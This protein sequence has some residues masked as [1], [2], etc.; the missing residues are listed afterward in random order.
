MEVYLAGELIAPSA[1]TFQLLDPDGT[2][3]IDAAA[4][5][6]TNDVATF[7]ISALDLPVTVAL[8]SG[9]V[10]VW[11][12]TMGAQSLVV[13]REAA[14]SK[15][16]LHCPVADV[17]FVAGE[18][19]DIV[20]SLGEYAGSLQGFIDEAFAQVVQRLWN[21]GQWPDL[22]LSSSALRQPL[23][24]MVMHLVMKFLYRKT[25]GDSRFER[26]MDLHY[27]RY[28][29]SYDRMTFRR[30]TDQDGTADNENRDSASKVIHRNVPPYRRLQKR[31]W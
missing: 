13:R 26:L 9:F 28:N 8:S 1:G 29:E 6:V 14:L 21:S 10:E 17:D 19:P 5:T 4:V 18:Y 24:E 23:R 31:N 11:S 3:R 30:D 22:I 12:L 2:S 27:D 15:Y 20:E 7:A 25:S 16:P